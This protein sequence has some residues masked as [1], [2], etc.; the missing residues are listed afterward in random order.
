M[1]YYVNYIGITVLLYN[2]I[3]INSMF[4]KQNVWRNLPVLEKMYI[5]PT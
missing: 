4:I 5:L 1:R 2:E 3:S